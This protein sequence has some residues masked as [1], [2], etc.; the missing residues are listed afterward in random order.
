MKKKQKEEKF[1]DVQAVIRLAQEENEESSQNTSMEKTMY[2]YK[3]LII[4]FKYPISNH[5][6]VFLFFNKLVVCKVQEYTKFL[7]KWLCP[8]YPPL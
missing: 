3:R 2:Y 4:R 8:C 1:V 6:K 5:C 7:K